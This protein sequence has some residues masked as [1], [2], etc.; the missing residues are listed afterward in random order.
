MQRSSVDSPVDIEKTTISH[1][2][3]GEIVAICKCKKL[4]RPSPFETRAYVGGRLEFEIHPELS[5]CD[6]FCTVSLGG[7]EWRRSGCSKIR[8]Q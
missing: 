1:T 3:R 6:V 5:R 8:L 7:A 2:G 4:R